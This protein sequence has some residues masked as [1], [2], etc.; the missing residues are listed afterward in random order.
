MRP[1]AADPLTSTKQLKELSDL[2]SATA[3]K[4]IISEGTEPL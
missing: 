3:S 4:A 1:C 2:N